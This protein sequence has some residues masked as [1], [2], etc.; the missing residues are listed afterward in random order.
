MPFKVYKI[1]SEFSLIDVFA[2]I[3][4]NVKFAMQAL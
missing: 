1:N 2:N 4:K 3:K